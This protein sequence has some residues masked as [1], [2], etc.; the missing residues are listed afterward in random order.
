MKV[1]IKQ[2]GGYTDRYGKFYQQ[3]SIADMPDALA[4]KLTRLGIVDIVGGE[5]RRPSSITTAAFAPP[6]TT[7]R[8]P[9]RPRKQDKD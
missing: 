5:T 6:E 9:G 1:K 2:G 3:N 4:A 8:P 7:T